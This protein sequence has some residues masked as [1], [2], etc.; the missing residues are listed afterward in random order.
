[1]AFQK[2]ARTIRSRLH[3]NARS[4]LIV[5]VVLVAALIL[6]VSGFTLLQSGS[7]GFS[8][9]KANASE[10]GLSSAPVSGSQEGVDD[11][12]PDEQDADDAEADSTASSAQDV[13]C[14]HVSGAVCEPGVYRLAAG[15]RV[16]DAVKAAGGFSDGACAEAINLARV[17]CDGEQ[18]LVPTTEQV[19]QQADASYASGFSDA[20]GGLVS[21]STD[22]GKVNINTADISTL[23]T[24]PGIGPATAERIV[25]DRES[26][27]LFSSIEDLK[28]VSGIGEKKYAQLADLVCVG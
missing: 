28:R 11:R 12:G 14:V 1:M 19:E 27:G 4:P 6:T 16:D 7:G 18:I 5:G 21:A 25:A 22:S 17:V 8:L 2:S 26:N 13:A 9:Q 3:M 20:S 15:S 24:L 10:A 23:D